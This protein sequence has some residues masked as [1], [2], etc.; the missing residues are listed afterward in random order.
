M[1]YLRKLRPASARESV[2]DPV[3]IDIDTFDRSPIISFLKVFPKFHIN[4]NEWFFNI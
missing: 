1:R 3:V 4:Q 2:T